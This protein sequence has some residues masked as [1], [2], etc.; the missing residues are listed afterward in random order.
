VEKNCRPDNRSGRPDGESRRQRNVIPNPLFQRTVTAGNIDT[1]CSGTKVQMEALRDSRQQKRCLH[2][3]K[4]SANADTLRAA[5]RE[6][7]GARGEPRCVP[8]DVGAEPRAGH[9]IEGEMHHALLHV[10]YLVTLPRVQHTLGALDH[11]CPYA[12]RFS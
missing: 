8:G 11:H 10:E 6:V 7:G 9:D 4:G 12:R 3:G 1:R 5:G 2:H